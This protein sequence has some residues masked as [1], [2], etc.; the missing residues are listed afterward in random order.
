M[1]YIS[2]WFIDKREIRI[3]TGPYHFMQQRR[4]A[5]GSAY[6]IVHPYRDFHDEIIVSLADRT[7]IAKPLLFFSC[8]QHIVFIFRASYVSHELRIGASPLPAPATAEHIPATCRL[9]GQQ[10]WT[11]INRYIPIDKTSL[12]H[13]SPSAPQRRRADPPS[14][15]CCGRPRDSIA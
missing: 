8:S 14:R 4:S 5:C 7:F 12:S 6:D 1:S 15:P 13:R 9:L 3:R 2:I 11:Y 10:L